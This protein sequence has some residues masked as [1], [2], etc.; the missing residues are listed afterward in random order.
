[1]IEPPFHYIH[2]CAS[3][4]IGNEREWRVGES[5]GRDE[6]PQMLLNILAQPRVAAA[7][8]QL[9]PTAAHE[10]FVKMTVRLDMGKQRREIGR[11]AR[12]LAVGP[13]HVL[14]QCV[15]DSGEI[16]DQ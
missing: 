9:D 8:Q 13:A 16:A 15:Y 2:D 14:A 5:L 1:V 3:Q 6:F 11:L 10:C 12:R 7:E 4:V